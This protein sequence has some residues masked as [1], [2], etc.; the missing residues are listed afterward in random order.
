MNENTNPK[1]NR[2][3]P[4]TPQVNPNLDSFYG[5]EVEAMLQKLRESTTKNR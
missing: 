1:Y 4:S 5:P 3:G 2:V